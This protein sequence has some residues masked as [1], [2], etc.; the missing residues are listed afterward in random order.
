MES[1]RTLGIG[2]EAR[3]LRAL[4]EKIHDIAG[5][6]MVGPLGMEVSCKAAGGVAEAVVGVVRRGGK[7]ALIEGVGL[8]RPFIDAAAASAR[9]DGC[10]KT[11]GGD[12]HDARR[13]WSP[14]ATHRVWGTIKNG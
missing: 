6:G 13:Y 4:H 5:F 9:V 8:E 1:Q 10:S 7:R 2:I 11:E 3:K 14:I 12:V